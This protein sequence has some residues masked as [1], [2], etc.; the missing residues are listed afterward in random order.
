MRLT[1]KFCHTVAHFKISSP[2]LNHIK[3]MNTELRKHLPK[4]TLE[5]KI[6][7]PSRQLY[8]CGCNYLFE[9]DVH[10]EQSST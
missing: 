2:G 5:Q 3:F 1:C 10:R 8:G 9:T 7:S 6:L 4:E